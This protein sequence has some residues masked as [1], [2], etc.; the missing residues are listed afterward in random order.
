[1]YDHFRHSHDDS[2]QLIRLAACGLLFLSSLAGTG[3]GKAPTWHAGYR[4]ARHKFIRYIIKVIPWQRNAAKKTGKD[5]FRMVKT[6]EQGTRN[7][8]NL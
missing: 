5:F 7:T 1:M 2:Q 8:E 6:I 4:H 3:S